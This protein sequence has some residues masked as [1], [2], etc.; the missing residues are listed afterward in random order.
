MTLFTLNMYPTLMQIRPN[1]YQ[2]KTS[3]EAVQDK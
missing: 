2:L 1:K 3:E